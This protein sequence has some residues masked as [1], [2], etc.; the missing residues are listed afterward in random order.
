MADFLE[1]LLPRLFP[2]FAF[3][4]V[5]HGGKKDLAL[6]VPRK[7][8]G[9]Q[10][11]GAKF[12]VMQDQDHAD[13]H[14]VKERLVQLCQRAGHNDALVRVV[15]RELEAWYLGEP[16]ALARAYPDRGADVLRKLAKPRYRDPDAIIEP[17]K[18]ITRLIPEF[19][20]REGARR[21]AGE[22]SNDTN[23]HSFRIFLTAV[24]RLR[25]A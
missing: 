7:L 6:S 25:T 3:K 12:V 4:C 1:K 22:L 19:Q 8:R 10:E 20:K 15:C 14:E 21:M 16:E 23:S 5:S 17:S 13:C 18:V 2:G 11:P 9:W 24:E